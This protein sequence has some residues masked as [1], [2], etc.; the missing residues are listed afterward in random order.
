[1]PLR[2]KETLN[3]SFDRLWMIGERL[4]PF[5]LSL[6]KHDQNQLN[7]SFLKSLSLYARP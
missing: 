6:S 4:I 3:K 1:M 7:Q 5:V 2:F